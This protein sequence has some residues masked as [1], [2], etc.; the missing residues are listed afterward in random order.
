LAGFEGLAKA[1]P[2]D[3]RAQ[4]YVS[5]CYRSIGQLLTSQGEVGQGMAKIEYALRI[6][7]KLKQSDP[8]NSDKLTDVA[9][10]QG[11]MADAYEALAESNGHSR[12]ATRDNWVQARQWYARSLNTWN[13]I[14][15]TGAISASNRAEPLRVEKQIQHCDV[16][17]SVSPT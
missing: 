15:R 8:T 7:Q 10:T 12:P 2:A 4:Q 5:Y 6:S 13:Q 9:Y 1:D 16:K 11:A 3:A 17:L 14:K